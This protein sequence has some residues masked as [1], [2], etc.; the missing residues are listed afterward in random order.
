MTAAAWCHDYLRVVE[1]QSVQKNLDLCLLVQKSYEFVLT[2]KILI[3]LTEE[4]LST[5][6]QFICIKIFFYHAA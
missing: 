1:L 3:P 5:A 4:V 6:K 2:L